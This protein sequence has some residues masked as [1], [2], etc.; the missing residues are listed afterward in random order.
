MRYKL[1]DVGSD[2]EIPSS[3][4]PSSSKPQTYKLLDVG[5]DTGPAD[6]SEESLPETAARYATYGAGKALNAFVD[7]PTNLAKLGGHVYNAGVKIGT[8]AQ[9]LASRIGLSDE[10]EIE[11]EHKP[12]FDT[13][14]IPNASDWTTKPLLKAITPKGW[15]DEE[16]SETQKKVG[17]GIEDFVSFLGGG[18]KKGIALAAS[19][20][21]TLA[22]WGAESV[23]ASPGVAGGVKLGTQILTHVVPGS[24]KKLHKYNNDLYNKVDAAIPSNASA[25][26]NE[27][28]PITRELDRKASLGFKDESN[29][30][31]RKI[32]NQL[33]KKIEG[34]P[35][36]YRVGSNK[37]MNKGAQPSNRIG[38]ES[39]KEFHPT[40]KG[41]EL[42]LKELS[43][44]SKQLNNDIFNDKVPKFAKHSI[45]KLRDRIDN[46]LGKELKKINPQAY[47]DLKEAK[48]I[49]KALHNQ[50][51]VTEF[52]SRNVNEKNLGY[53]SGLVLLGKASP[54]TAAGVVATGIGARAATQVIDAFRQSPAIRKYYK[55]L[56]SAAAGKSKQSF[57]REVAKFDKA[58]RDYEEK[59]GVQRY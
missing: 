59:Y 37:S 22:K 57:L 30:Y 41:G 35:E 48:E 4:Q 9:N 50:A 23:G 34:A 49:F 42:K 26:V 33:K 46:V 55:N 8:G 36:G 27:L 45:N 58:S 56:V 5:E 16:S 32:N 13:E 38:A 24:I 47:S 12:Y 15:I 19:A 44:I 40:A 31:L 25:R 39:A 2:T 29:A 28:R 21:G 52:I 51:P 3:S 1:L 7:I 53:I 6:F 43:H 18:A 10:P 14:K 54:M 20:G 11:E 17:E